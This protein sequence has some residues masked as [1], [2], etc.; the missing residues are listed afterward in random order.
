MITLKATSASGSKGQYIA[1]ITGRDPKFTFA[2][3]FV[4]RQD[5]RGTTTQADIDEPG[6]YVLGE[7]DRKGGKDE[8]FVVVVPRLGL[9]L[10]GV[11]NIKPSRYDDSIVAKNISKDEAMKIAKALEAGDQIGDLVTLSVVNGR[12]EYDLPTKAERAKAAASQPKPSVDSAV[13][14]CWVILSALPQ[15]EAEKAIQA[16]QA[17]ISQAG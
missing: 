8:T 17:R 2:R 16:I 9:S 4:G 5:S 1:R 14:A 10:D 6:L 12:V 3:V 11:T 15:E 7:V 13:E